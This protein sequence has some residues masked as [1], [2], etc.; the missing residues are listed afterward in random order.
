MVRIQWLKLTN[1]GPSIEIYKKR[2]RDKERRERR[3]RK[4]ADVIY[5]QNILLLFFFRYV[6]RVPRKKLELGDSWLTFQ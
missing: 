5:I 1:L 3:V 2:Q 6:N 4:R